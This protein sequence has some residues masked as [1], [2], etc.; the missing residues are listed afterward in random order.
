MHESS[1]LES[2]DRIGTRLCRDAVWSG[3]RCNW[4]GWALEVVSGSWSPVY[5]AQGASLYDGT[6]GIALFLGRL[7]SFTQDP[8][9]RITA[10]GALNQATTAAASVEP[11]LRPSLYSGTTGIAYATIQLGFELSDDRM[12]AQG[13]KALREAAKIPDGQIWMDIIGG[14]AGAIQALLELAQRLDVPE[15][16]E[17][18]V[19]HGKLLLQSAVKSDKGW[20]W[21]TLPGQSEKHLL[22]Y[23]HGAAGIGCALLELWAET[24]DAQYREAA[25]EAFRYE[26]GYFSPQDHNWPDLRSMAA[27]GVPENQTVFAL[28][29]CHGGP[30]IGL[31]RLRAL[32]LLEDAEI[33]HDLDEAVQLTA[34]AC[35]NVAFPASG[36]L[37]LCH[38]LGGNAELM[39]CTADSHGRDDLRQIAENIG[40][41]ANI[42]VQLDNF[43]WPCGVT[44]AGETPNL[45][46]G[47]AGIGHFY[48]RLYDSV[49]VGSILLV[50]P[51]KGHRNS[52]STAEN[53][54]RTAAD[55]QS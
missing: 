4:L 29:W 51:G 5:R 28:A 10:L 14:S 1:F 7:Y 11:G 49:Q 27:Y 47:L 18:A 42:Q 36:S 19:S 33:A 26:R 3:Q 32:E 31:S 20:S 12:L 6:A 9:Q 2:A 34:S 37:C 23:G 13:L 54:S 25:V 40:H 41:Q 35:S 45:M 21:D 15:L 44:G 30:G 38:G 46:L 24:G 17:Q 55:G 22:G 53:L 52:R 43:P 8:L 16:V 48:L 50:G 39:L